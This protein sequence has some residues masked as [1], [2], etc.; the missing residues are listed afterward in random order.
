MYYLV[1][2]KEKMTTIKRGYT[3]T[4]IQVEKLTLSLINTGKERYDDL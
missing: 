3:L 4:K 2:E 1:S